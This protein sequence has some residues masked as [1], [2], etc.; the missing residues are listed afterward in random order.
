MSWKLKY[1]CEF[2]KG[3]NIY[4]EKFFND[5]EMPWDSHQDVYFMGM[6]KNFAKSYQKLLNKDKKRKFIF[7]TIQDFQRDM[8]DLDNYIKFAKN[9]EYLCEDSLWVIESGKDVNKPNLHYHA[10]IRI[11]ECFSKH[12]KRK[13]CMEFKKKFGADISQKDYYCVKQ[14]NKSEKMPPYEQWCEEK[15]DYL[16]NTIKGDH[17]NCHDLASLGGRGACGVLTSFIEPL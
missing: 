17:T 13:V 6:E 2:W 9:I 3:Y 1:D 12:F 4:M 8:G 5:P 15:R 10:L 16:D 11:K 14:W 7:L